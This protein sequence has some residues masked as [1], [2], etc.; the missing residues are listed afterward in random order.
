MKT[1]KSVCKKC[2]DASLRVYTASIRRLYNLFSEE[3]S[4]P[5]LEDFPKQ[6]RWLMSEK[7]EKA[8]KNLPL[9][10]RRHLSAAAVIAGKMYDLDSDN[11]WSKFMKKDVDEY[12]QKRN[13]NKMSKY[14]HENIPSNG[15]KDIKKALKIY[16][17]QI[18]N[19]FT[20]KASLANLYKWQ[21]Y[22]ALK[23]MSTSAPVRN[24]LPTLDIETET[25]NYLKRTKNSFTI[26]L[27]QFKNSKKL[28]PRE[29][30][31]NRANNM[32]VKKFL[33]YRDKLDLPHTKLFSLRSGKPM[34]KT[35]F[36]QGL[37]KLTNKLLDKKIGSRL[38]RVMY[39]TQ[40]SDTLQK[41]SEITDKMLHAE[42]GKQT[43]Q[44][45]KK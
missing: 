7:L 12:E 4:A 43:R 24:D 36:S 19:I 30:K 1:L 17:T 33:K 31:L 44:Y 39:A 23:L 5:K 14:E 35:A 25:G 26:V 9:K 21:F 2:S 28:G 15:L 40:H 41:A 42:G 20:K 18:K 10:S 11:K 22:L 29:I 6:S 3:D 32:E 27:Q 16:R 37:I 13:Q 38:L 8:Y 45:V 34:T